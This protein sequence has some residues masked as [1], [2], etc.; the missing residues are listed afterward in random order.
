MELTLSLLVQLNLRGGVVARVLQLLTEVLDI[1]GE[2]RSILL[3]FV[4]VLSL[5]SELLLKLL[6][7]CL[8]L[9]DLLAV[10]TAQSVLV[11]YLG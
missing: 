6:N 1:S 8:K 7:P 11:L 10:L 4:P 3:C 5:N 2:S 9:F